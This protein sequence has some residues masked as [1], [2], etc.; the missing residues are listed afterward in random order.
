[1][2]SKI[3]IIV[4]GTKAEPKLMRHLL[5]VYH[6]ADSHEIV[7]YGTN[8]YALYNEMFHDGDPETIDLHQLLR[9]R[10]S[11]DEQKKIFDVHYS[12]TLLIFDLDPQDPQYRPEKIA[13]MV[14]YFTESS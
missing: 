11:N 1:M 2:K 13:E 5:D 3:L 4:E 8:I 12:D 7:S 9:E 14:E 10:E 6:I